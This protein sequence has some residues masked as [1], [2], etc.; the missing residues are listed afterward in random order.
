MEVLYAGCELEP[1]PQGEWFRDGCPCI[2]SIIPSWN[3]RQTCAGVNQEWYIRH[4]VYT[5]QITQEANVQQDHTCDNGSHNNVAV[6][7]PAVN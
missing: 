1:A 7:N 5:I 2:M 3:L 6:S 4:I